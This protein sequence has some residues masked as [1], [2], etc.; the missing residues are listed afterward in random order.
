MGDW[1]DQYGNMASY[2]FVYEYP[3]DEEENLSVLQ[4]HELYIPESLVRLAEK[5]QELFEKM[6]TKESM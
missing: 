3:K 5:E 4:I 1:K 2:I 6:N